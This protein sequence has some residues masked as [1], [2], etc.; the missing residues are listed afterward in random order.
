MLFVVSILLS[1]GIILTYK[2]FSKNFFIS[3]IKEYQNVCLIFV[4]IITL[5]GILYKDSFWNVNTKPFYEFG[6]K[7]QNIVPLN[8]KI[9]Y[10]S[11]PQDLWC[12][13]N[14][15]VILDP[16]N[17]A[18]FSNNYR[19]KRTLEELNFYKPD[20]L[21]L[22]FSKHIYDRSSNDLYNTINIHYDFNLKLELSDEINHYYLYKI[23]Y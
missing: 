11:T 19:K 17:M 7:I 3:K 8:S 15:Q 9:M 12:V 10:G 5:S 2:K 1:N 6:K 14:R 4:F 13:S 21:F 18:N 23:N 20:Y 16:N 22:D